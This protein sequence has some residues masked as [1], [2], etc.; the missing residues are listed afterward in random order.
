M[1]LIFKLLFISIFLSCSSAKSQSKIKK[2]CEDCQLYMEPIFGENFIIGVDKNTVKEKF[3][4]FEK[5][6]LDNAEI[7]S[8]SEIEYY[9][10]TKN[11]FLSNN[12]E[13]LLQIEFGFKNDKLIKFNILL[14]IGNNK[15]NF[16]KKIISILKKNDVKK[17]NSFLYKDD[18]FFFYEF[19]DNCRKIFSLSRNPN[20]PKKFNLDVRYNYEYDIPIRN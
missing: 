20:N 16:F 6:A 15:D 9:T 1:K 19:K 4:N 11:V 18:E 12:T 5:V 17:I 7:L 13:G 14:D 10:A 8:N 2:K 3:S